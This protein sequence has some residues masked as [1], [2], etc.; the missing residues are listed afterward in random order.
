MNKHKEMICDECKKIEERKFIGKIKGKYLCRK[1]RIELRKKH[2]EQTIN[3]AGIKEELHEL[4]NKRKREWNTSEKGRKY[5][6]DYNELKIKGSKLKREKHYNFLP[7]KERQTLFR[8]LIGRGM[9]T[10]EVKERIENLIESQEELRTNLKKKN[11]SEEE[12]RLKQQ[13]MLEE[14]WNY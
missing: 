7:F 3:N 8:I 10:D 4:D 11:K 5:Y 6:R 14:L 13:E 12:I 2:R 1:C 9:E